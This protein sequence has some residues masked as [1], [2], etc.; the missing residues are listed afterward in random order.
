M[1]DAVFFLVLGLGS[2]AF[3][4]ALALGVI[5]VHRGTGVV[6]FALGAQ[7]M[8]PAVV[9]A[10]LRTSGDLLLPVIV[11][12]N[13]YGLGD[14][15]PFPA[16]FAIALAVGAMV[17]A[18]AY[19]VVFRP[20]R[21]AQPLTVIVATVGVVIVLQ[22]LAL[23][24]FGAETVRTPPILPRSNINLLGRPL[25]V[26]RLWLTAGVVAVAFVLTVVYRRTRFG[27]AT[28]AAA[29]SERGA[30]FLGYDLVRL[31]TL[32]WM[33][34]SLIVGT[35][36][37]LVTPLSGVSPFTYTGFVVP[38]LAAALAGRLRSFG[39]A[40]LAGL[41]IG[42]FQALTVH[43]VAQGRVPD[44]LRA[45]LDSVLPLLVIVVALYVVGQTLPT[46]GT[47]ELYQRIHLIPART[48]PWLW[49]SLLFAAVLLALTGDASL[50]L[51]LI[52]S[53]WVVVLLLSIV[54]I[55]GLTGQ[56][57]LAQL[58]FAG[59][60]AFVL[61]KVS[62]GWGV[63]FPVG[64]IL[65]VTITTAVGVLVGVPALRIRGIQ[66]AI[67]TFAAAL[68]F[69]RLVFRSPIFVG[70]SGVAH[71]EQ[72][73]LFGV[74]LGIMIEG[75]FPSRRFAVGCVI[76]AWLCAGLVAR[77][78][79]GS[80]GRRM[81]AVR[82]NERA[83]AACGIDV[84]RQKLLAAGIGSSLA[85]IAGVLLAYKSIDL[86]SGGFEPERSLQYLALAFLGGI[87]NVSGAVIGGVL[88][89]SGLLI[90]A[91]SSGSLNE[92]I[93]LAI[94]FAVLLAT[95]YLPEGLAG[96]GHRRAAQISIGRE[97]ELDGE[98]PWTP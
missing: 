4:A 32:N 91:L 48:A 12:P 80:T 5:V 64:P 29:E 81:L 42:A 49:A 78:R 28:R 83:A 40:A 23:R 70:G 36:G 33:L 27:L 77:L 95:R 24:S 88:A 18:V 17:S 87:G 63:P 93:V 61:S 60:A 79:R 92:D 6:N 35:I 44:L 20:L 19:L 30:V 71:V 74:E 21:Q 2:G 90:V 84:V 3:Y 53:A 73:E 69:E 34:A 26:D 85:A 94:G 76:T 75:Q 58:S 67:V 72:P 15:L 55:T 51:A 82:M 86:T 46:R 25:P 56:I 8:Y 54:V 89:P 97:R 68:V 13:R 41:A 7:A 16:A 66:Y 62:T 39:W 98:P 59:V 47:V 37:I 31:G 43:L 38:A 14:P 45:G 52:Q 11:L 1:T 65:A 10:E 22:G 96:I 50:R 57:S 9:Y